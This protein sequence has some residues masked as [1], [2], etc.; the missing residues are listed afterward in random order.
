MTE[1][2]LGREYSAQWAL[3]IL[4]N[5]LRQSLNRA[6]DHNDCDIYFKGR[7]H[8]L[9]IAIHAIEAMAET[10]AAGKVATRIDGES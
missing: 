4:L 9:E 8:G 10:C 3:D 5:I 1:N 2:E 6:P 7:A